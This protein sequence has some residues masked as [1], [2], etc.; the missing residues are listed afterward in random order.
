MK[1]L[2]DYVL[3]GLIMPML[4]FCGSVN[5]DPRIA[6]LDFELIDITSLPNTPK[7]LI[8]TASIKPLLEQ[9]LHQEGDYDVVQI[10]P[11]T[12]KV[13]NSGQSYLFRFHDIAAKLGDPLDADWI[14]VGQH[15]KPS[16]L[17]SYLM[18]NLVNVK[19]GNLEARY[20]IELKGT[21]AK[22]TKRGVIRL[23]M[24]I[25]DT[26]INSP[27]LVTESIPF[28]F[29]NTRFEPVDFR[30]GLDVEVQ[31]ES[32]LSSFYND[33]LHEKMRAEDR[34]SWT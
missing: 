6:I 31:E 18:V 10:D 32:S 14:I 30:G 15:S 28:A 5:A 21:H 1:T 33:A 27:A 22:V 29:K 13:A 25:I 12:Q 11:N 23:A 20:A 2:R 24:E 16:H 26:I 4:I 7:E 3:S 19:T 17:I 34:Y 9:A 8:R